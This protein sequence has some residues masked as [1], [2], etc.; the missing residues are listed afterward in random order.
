M[1]RLGG[2]KKVFFLGERFEQPKINCCSTFRIWLKVL[3][4]DA[5]AK[6]VCRI[7]RKTPEPRRLL[8]GGGGGIE[9]CELRRVEAPKKRYTPLLVCLCRYGRPL[10]GTLFAELSFKWFPGFWTPQYTDFRVV[11]VEGKRKRGFRNQLGAYTHKVIGRLG[12]VA[13]HLIESI[14]F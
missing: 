6:A 13:L 3:S 11:G 2:G 1:L 7:G 5:T 14:L 10:L 4:D 8:F 12:F 9:L